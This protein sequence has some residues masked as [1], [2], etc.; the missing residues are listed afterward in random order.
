MAF[1]VVC[2][3]GLEVLSAPRGRGHCRPLR[4]TRHAR[5]MRDVRG[6]CVLAG[7]TPLHIAGHM[8]R[9]EAVRFLLQA[10]GGVSPCELECISTTTTKQ[11]MRQVVTLTYPDQ[12]RFVNSLWFD[13]FWI[14]SPAL[15]RGGG[16]SQSSSTECFRWG[17]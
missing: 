7:W 5:A 12:D 15:Q 6:W 9:S 16:A 17:T 14:C 11:T 3:R 1:A 13:P 10:K 4:A 8:G 2:G